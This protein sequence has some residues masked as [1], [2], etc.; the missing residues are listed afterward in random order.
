MLAL[1][2]NAVLLVIQF[3]QRGRL[4]PHDY[5]VAAESLATTLVL[6]GGIGFMFSRLGKDGDNRP[7]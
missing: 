5:L 2:V 1:A 3:K 6:L 4:L 7:K